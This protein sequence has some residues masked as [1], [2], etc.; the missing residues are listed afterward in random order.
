MCDAT[1][2]AISGKAA[3]DFSEYWVVLLL[4]TGDAVINLICDSEKSVQSQGIEKQSAKMW[5]NIT[6]T[7]RYHICGPGNNFRGSKQCQWTPKTC[8]DQ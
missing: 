3:I 7:S 5:K 1:C 8:S 6:K 2:I 4:G